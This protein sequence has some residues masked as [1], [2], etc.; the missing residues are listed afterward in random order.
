[1]IISSYQINS[2]LRVYGDQLR[3]SRNPAKMKSDTTQMADKISISETARRKSIIDKVAS[4]I[5]EKITQNGPQDNVEKEVVKR[6]ED[7]Y[8]GVVSFG[9]KAASELI[10][11]EIDENGETIHSLSIKDSDFL[12]H[13]LKEITQKTIGQIIE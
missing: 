4:D 11:K 8:G 13:R 12:T 9:E 10:F 3:N 2:V 7:E 1:M 5:L 6:F